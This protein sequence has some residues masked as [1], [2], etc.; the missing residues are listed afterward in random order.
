MRL[1]NENDPMATLFK[2]AAT[3]AIV[4]IENLPTRDSYRTGEYLQAE[5]YTVF[6][7]TPAGGEILGMPAIP[8]LDAIP[9]PVDIVVL[10][11]PPSDITVY[12]EAAIR[13]KAKAL[14]LQ[15]GIEHE[16]AAKSAFEA[17]LM[18]VQDRDIVVEHKRLIKGI[19]P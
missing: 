6:P 1:T 19:T 13:K 15:L 3:V 18:V 5:G 11:C 7:V 2:E 10:F 16:A 4:G 8:L 12:A 17:G 9:A 14:W